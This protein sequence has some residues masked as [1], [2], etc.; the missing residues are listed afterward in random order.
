MVWT[1]TRRCAIQTFVPETTLAGSAAVLDRQRL[2]KQRV[3]TKQILKALLLGG[4]GWAN[5]PA[6]R[7]WRGHEGFLAMYGVA[8]C[9]EWIARGYKDSLRAEF[10]AL[11]NPGAVPAASLA[12]PT[13]WLGPIHESHRAN[14]VR[15]LPDHYGP[16][17][18]DVDPA[19]PYFW[20]V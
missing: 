14:L 9:D 16:M 13:W 15:K 10:D 11:L 12:P 5:H 18:P 7:M 3:E 19:M 20:P 4:S 6:V 2:G 17:W 1:Q 8:V